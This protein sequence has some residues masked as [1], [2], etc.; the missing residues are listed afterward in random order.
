MKYKLAFHISFSDT[1]K[2]WNILSYDNL[3]L[4]ILD[5][6]LF[7]T[8]FFNFSLF[9]EYFPLLHILQNYFLSSMLSHPFY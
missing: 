7:L 1:L 4:G 2:I 6:L 5:C 9:Y 3:G 8:L